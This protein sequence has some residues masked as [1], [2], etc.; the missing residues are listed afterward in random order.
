MLLAA[1]LMLV[2]PVYRRHHRIPL[3]SAAMLVTVTG[4]SVGL[5]SA[6][7][8][9]HADSAQPGKINI[10]EAVANLD[11]RLQENPDD[12]D[13]W[14]M[15]GRSYMEIGNLPKAVASLEKAV[16]LEASGN[17]ETLIMLGEALFR[18]D[19]ASITGRAGRLFESGLALAPSDPR[20]LFFGGLA[21]ASRGAKLLAADRW[22][23]FLAQ[24]PPMDMQDALRRRI[25]EW[26]GEEATGAPPPTARSEAESAPVVSV[27]VRIGDT[28]A[29]GID[30]D[31]SVFIIARDPEKPAPP[32][33]VVRRRATE[34]PAVVAIGDSNAMIPGRLPSAYAQLEIV[35]RVSASGKPLAQSGDWFGQGIFVPDNGQ[36]ISIVVDQQVP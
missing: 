29:S 7:G 4:L 15:L 25:A 27:N 28:A 34:L 12:V 8:T 33:A 18:S 24:A 1:C 31:A 23:K 36:S 16:K 26:R 10:E 14:K 13:G 32:V 11:A 21:A 35:V 22:E 6:I 9:P 17:G 5:Y 19:T 2:W 20:G 30:P 3:I